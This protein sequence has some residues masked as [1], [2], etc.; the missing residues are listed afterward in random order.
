MA[1]TKY[2]YSIATDTAN[3]FANINTLDKEIRNSAIV[4]ALDYISMMGDVL[5]VYMKD[6]LSA[7]DETTLDGLI[8]AHTGEALPDD[9]IQKVATKEAPPFAE[10]TILVNGVTKKIYKRIHGTS[11]TVGAG[12]TVDIDFTVPHAHCKF[13]G[14]EIINCDIGDEVDYTVHDTSTNTYSGAPTTSPGYPNYLLNQFGFNVKMP[15]KY[16]ANTSEYDA[17]VYQ[18]MIIRCS[19]TNNTG[20]SKTI[21][22]NVWLHEVKD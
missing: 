22:T 18:N 1:Q 12:A 6:A 19:Y 3:G 9:Y 13:T 16:Y 11:A 15:E 2:T 20:S 7:G 10:K 14:A 17:D 8:S 4:T 5:D 21:Y